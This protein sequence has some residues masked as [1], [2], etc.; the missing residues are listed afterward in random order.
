MLSSSLDTLTVILGGMP[1][2]RVLV[3]ALVRCVG[4][5]MAA[6]MCRMKAVVTSG[7]CVMRAGTG[8]KVGRI[9]T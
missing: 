7:F 4:R 5:G 3:Q 9:G 1:L 8:V 2:E 6:G